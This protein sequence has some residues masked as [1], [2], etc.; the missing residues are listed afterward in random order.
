MIWLTVLL[1]VF[2]IKQVRTLDNRVI[3]MD[4][5]YTKRPVY[6]SFWAL[7]CSQCIK[8]LDRVNELKDSLNV[9]VITINEDG[10]RKK[11]RVSAFAKGRKWQFPVSI[12]ERQ[13]LM[14][15]MGVVALPSSFLYDRD[16]KCVKK[17]TGFSGKAEET[18]KAL[19][20]SLNHV[21]TLSTP[22]N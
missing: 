7:W 5:I 1:A 16:G 13:K 21:D 6:V 18:F 3:D 9:F 17:F 11:A 20:D 22:A 2:P 8:E 14:R 19:I 4:T 12:D 15:E 10:N